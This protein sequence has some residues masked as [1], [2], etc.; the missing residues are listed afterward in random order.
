MRRWLVEFT[1]LHCAIMK[2][3]QRLNLK[4]RSVQ[5][6]KFSPRV[7]TSAEQ[8]SIQSRLLRSF[9]YVGVEWSNSVT[10]SQSSSSLYWVQVDRS[11]ATSLRSALRLCRPRC[12]FPTTSTNNMKWISSLTPIQ[13]HA[14]HLYIYPRGMFLLARPKIRSLGFP[15]IIQIYT[16]TITLD[17]LMSLEKQ[18]QFFLYNRFDFQILSRL[19]ID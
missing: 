12:Y 7:C 14:L 18:Y 5:C 3:S 15:P 4:F 6:W 10:W 19:K 11:F 16:F 2:F 17:P 1:R 8:W 13:Y 9:S